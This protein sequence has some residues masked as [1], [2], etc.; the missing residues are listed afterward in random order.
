MKNPTARNCEGAKSYQKLIHNVPKLYS[1]SKKQVKSVSPFSK[2][3]LAT[4]QNRDNLIQGDAFACKE[5]K[6]TEV[7]SMLASYSLSHNTFSGKLESRQINEIVA[8][9][10]NI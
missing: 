5:G 8:R 9:G 1:L 10:F 2:K 3:L 4:Y 6:P 7:G